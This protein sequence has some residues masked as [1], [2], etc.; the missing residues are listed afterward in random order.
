M[1][2]LIC[3]GYLLR[4][5]GSNQYVQS[6]ARAFCAQG[7]H[8]LV[9]C[10]D[11]DPRLDFVSAFLCEQDGSF[12]PQVLWEEKT[13]YTG[14]CMV[15]KPDIGGL[16]PVYVLDSY[17]GFKVKEFTELSELELDRYVD[18]NRR[19]LQRLVRQFAPEAIHAN[20]AV[21]LPYIVR[22]VASEHEIPYFVSIHGSAI[23]YTVKKDSRYLTYGAEGLE[24]AEAIL[25]PSEHTASQ[26]L[27]V[28]GGRVE[29]LEEKLTLLPPGVDTELFRPAEESL[30]ESVE[31]MLAAVEKRT[32]GVTVGDFIGRAGDHPPAEREQMQVEYEI[33]RINGLHPEWLPDPDIEAGMRGLAAGGCPFVMYLGKLLETKG[34]QCVITALPLILRDHPTAKL[35]VVGFGELWGILELMID[36]LDQGEIRTF[37]VLCEY[38]NAA[39]SKRTGR[40]FAPV[41]AFLD[42][43]A[44]EGTLDDY[45]R[46]CLE[47]DLRGAVIFT[48]YLAPEEH[49]YI[50]PHARALLVPSL[51][52][53][54]FGLVATEAMAAGVVPIASFHSGLESALDPVK[55]VWGRDAGLFLLGTTEKLV[56]RIAAACGTVLEM[57][58]ESL[59]AR[60][61]EM[62][63]V[64]QKRFT[65][66][67]AARRLA[68]LY[69][70]R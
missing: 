6:L 30:A 14:T 47:Q 65:W 8:V 13:G 61:A 19:S 34:I 62:R 4:G 3:H 28:F 40:P 18:M 50:L 25:V 68:A 37:K 22:P 53:E 45:L 38:G 7:H 54:A 55:A 21:M 58:D 52:Q 63:S 1:R 66:D 56:F 42:E 15:F 32:E 12:T 26:V 17:A 57:P 67:A 49:R 35:V 51:A 29:G 46:L 24:G 43:L 70:C 48:G 39:Y 64:V 36:A 16:L 27:E 44:G 11:G 9:M 5:T 31:Q 59:R 69:E 23:E 2:I 41:L 60:G 10:Q 20:H 33:S